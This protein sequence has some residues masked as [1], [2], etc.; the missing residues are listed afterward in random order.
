MPILSHWF[1][2]TYRGLQG[3]QLVTGSS[4]KVCHLCYPQCGDRVAAEQRKHSPPACP[5]V[6][7]H[8]DPCQTG[9]YSSEEPVVVEP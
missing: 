5:G 2:G 1:S 7:L 6:N 9:T 8:I 3:E 4:W